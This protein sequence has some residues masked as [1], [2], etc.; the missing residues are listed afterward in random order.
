MK[1]FWQQE[2]LFFSAEDY[3]QA[4]LVDIEQARSSLVLESYIFHHDDTGH[5]VLSALKSA[6]S[7][8]VAVRVLIDGVGSDRDAHLIAAELVG[9]GVDAR[10]FRPLP[11]NFSIFRHAHQRVAG[12]RRW[13]NFLLRINRRNHRKLCV[14]DGRIAWVGSFNITNDHFGREGLA[15][16]DLAAR[17]EDDN[18]RQLQDSFDDIWRR[19]NHPRRRDR[20]RNFFSNHSHRMRQVKNAHLI[21][22]IQHAKHRIWI[23]N[24]YFSPSLDFLKALAEA[25]RRGV[26]VRVMV[27]QKSDIFLFPA[28]SSTY[29]ADLLKAGIGVYEYQNRILHEKSMLIDDLAIVGS[30]NLNYRSLFHDLELDVLLNQ[31]HSI[32]E[33]SSRFDADLKECV[34][35]TAPRLRRYPFPLLWL[36]WL[37]RLFRYWL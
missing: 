30:T 21:K 15:W 34:E 12:W 35:I 24:A 22:L 6:A 33:L 16:K 3:F 19:I 31:P 9:C 1:Y 36:G 32:R 20:L 4:L 11:W 14:I 13:W 2:K 5:R 10:I 37:S 17:V 26:Q 18:V 8:G 25:N 28:L 7:R 29:Y 27:P 23:T